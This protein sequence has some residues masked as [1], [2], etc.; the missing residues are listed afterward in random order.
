[1]IKFSWLKYGHLITVS[2]M[3]TENLEKHLHESSK[4]LLLF[5]VQLKKKVIRPSS[6][7]MNKYILYTSSLGFSSTGPLK[8]RFQKLLRLALAVVTGSFSVD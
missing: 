8:K 3:Y 7:A 5:Y 2:I 1:M 6:V 4:L